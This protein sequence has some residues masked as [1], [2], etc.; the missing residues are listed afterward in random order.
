LLTEREISPR[1]K[2]NSS[3]RQLE[4]AFKIPEQKEVATCGSTVEQHANV[5]TSMQGLGQ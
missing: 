1:K 2:K 4:M 5:E 3:C